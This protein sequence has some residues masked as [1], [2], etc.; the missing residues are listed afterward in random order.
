MMR[1]RQALD[2]LVPLLDGDSVPGVHAGSAGKGKDQGK[3]VAGF[4]ALPSVM[5]L[6]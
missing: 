4:V 2:D 6:C 5:A 3:W 1:L